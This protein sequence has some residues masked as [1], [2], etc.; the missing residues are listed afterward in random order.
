MDIHKLR[1]P[2]GSE[3][4]MMYANANEPKELHVVKNAKHSDMYDVEE[5]VLE[6]IEQIKAFF[7]KYL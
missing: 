2:V 3:P 5:Y 4:L 1:P 7:E 6:N